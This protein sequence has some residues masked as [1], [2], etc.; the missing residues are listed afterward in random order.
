ME[1]IIFHL[2]INH[3]YAQIEEMLHPELRHVA[4]AVGGH[5]ENR[6]GIILAK[7]DLAKKEGIQTGES[8]REAYAKDENLLIIPPHYD[9]Y[10]YYTGKVKEIYREYSD[11]VES[12]GLDEAWVDYTASRRLF[13]EP[14]EVCK[15]IIKRVKE[16]LGL[17]VSA[18]ISW[19][20]VFAKLGSD[21]KKKDGPYIITK[22][23]YKE[24]VWNLPVQD[25]LYVGPATYRKLVRRAIFTIG[26][27]AQYPVCHLK[28]AMGVAGEMIWLFANGEDT[29]PVSE[30]N[31][32]VKPKSIGNSM[33]M[34]H[35][36]KTLEE[37]KPVFYMLCE[38]VASRLKDEGLAGNTLHITLRTNDLRWFGW[39][40]KMLQSTNVSED[41][42]QEVLCLLKQYSF[43]QPL[44]AVGIS[45]SQL[46]NDDKHQVDLFESEEAH[47][48]RRKM[49][50]AMDE[51][52]NRYGF[53][54]I[55]RACTLLDPLLTDFNAKEDHT[56]HPVGYLNGRKMIA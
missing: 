9:E 34:V 53:H 6:H 10:M 56:I 50:F 30:V 15:Q 1:R 35:D 37:V 36:T 40:R 51:I 31:S 43:E 28:K 55:F 41:L 27:L 32:Y 33:T 19:N 29:S 14:E 21:Q 3:C 5:E 54:A 11:L 47:E 24:T 22:E 2:D 18:G 26:D 8:L 25:L 42:M 38:S 7:N 39:E 44:R 45:V 46:G 49:D 4:M 13:G 52:R 12:F 16:E 23:N 17:D 48:K 20:K